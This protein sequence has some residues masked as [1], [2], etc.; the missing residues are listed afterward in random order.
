MTDEHEDRDDDRQQFVPGA[1]GRAGQGDGLGRQE[2]AMPS[3]VRA[4][5]ASAA[6]D[7][8]VDVDDRSILRPGDQVAGRIG[9]APVRAVIASSSPASM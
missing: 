4:A 6:R 9:A 7:R 5:T 1:D 8:Q 3:V 2:P